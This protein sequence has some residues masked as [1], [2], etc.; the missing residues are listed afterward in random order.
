MNKLKSI[1]FC[2]LALLFLSCIGEDLSECPP[3]VNLE[4]TFSY[5]GDTDDP[6]MFVSYIDQVTLMVYDESERLVLSL[7]LNKNDLTARQG[8]ELCLEPGNYKIIC[9]G[10]AHEYTELYE[11]ES[12]A[13]G[14]LNHPSLSK[15]ERIPTNSHL[16][17]GS[18][19]VSVPDKGTVQGDIPFCGAHINLEVYVRNATTVFTKASVEGLQIE[20]HNLMP[21]YNMGMLPVQAYST[22]YYPETTFNAEKGLNQALFQALRFND[23][24]PVLIEVKDPSGTMN[25]HVQLKKYMADYKISVNNKN[26]ATVPVLVE[27]TDLGAEIKLPEWIINEVDPGTR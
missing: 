24:N 10:N 25:C 26:E 13:G 11:C 6:S 4:L 21:Q 23:D 27:F 18:Y 17:Y 12:F 5:R 2:S 16:Y 7:D 8:V 20:A 3:T 1:L 15:S 14:K 9:W 22:T 19:N